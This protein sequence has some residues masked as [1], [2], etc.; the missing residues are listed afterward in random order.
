MRKQTAFAIVAATLIAE[1][2]ANQRGRNDRRCAIQSH[3]A[4][5]SRYS[6]DAHPV[7]LGQRDGASLLNGVA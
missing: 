1:F 2:I 7:S 4:N 6:C 3:R 5:Y